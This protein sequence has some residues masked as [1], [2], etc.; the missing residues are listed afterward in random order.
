LGRVQGIF[1]PDNKD[2]IKGLLSE[3]GLRS[4]EQEVEQL[5]KIADKYEPEIALLESEIATL[6]ATLNA[7]T[8]ES[9][10]AADL[11]KSAPKEEKDQHKQNISDKE[12]K[13]AEI[14]KEIAKK[15]NN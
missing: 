6:N 8:A 12:S 3:K 11:L 4:L 5:E 14:I 9:G 1:L 2:L 13:I 15:P 10:Q 7:L